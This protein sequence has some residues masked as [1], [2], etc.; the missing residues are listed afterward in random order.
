[1][2]KKSI[3]TPAASSRH[4][5]IKEDKAVEHG[6]FA[7]VEDGPEAPRGVCHEVGYGHLSGQNKGSRPGEQ[8]KQNKQ[9]TEE[10]QHTGQS[11]EREE[12]KMS[13][14]R[15]SRYSKELLAP[16]LHEEQARRY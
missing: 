3:H 8:A 5:Q 1:M 14:L 7:F 16:V 4:C 13:G 11:H 9:A 10:F 12:V 2:A 6:Q 15:A